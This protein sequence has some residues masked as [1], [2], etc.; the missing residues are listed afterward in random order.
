MYWIF[1][2]FMLISFLLHGDGVGIK[3][4]HEMCVPNRK[5][6]RDEHLMRIQSSNNKLVMMKAE[7]KHI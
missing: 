6:W 7:Q 3:I 5:N 2:L 1:N 4:T